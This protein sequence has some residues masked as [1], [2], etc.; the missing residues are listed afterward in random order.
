MTTEK[1]FSKL[2]RKLRF[3]MKVHRLFLFCLVIFTRKDKPDV[4]FKRLTL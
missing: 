1:K 2:Q 3:T 4:S